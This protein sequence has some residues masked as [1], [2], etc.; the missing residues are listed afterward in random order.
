MDGMQKDFPS[1]P[2]PIKNLKWSKKAVSSIWEMGENLKLL[3][4][5]D[6]VKAAL[7]F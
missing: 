6:T 2:F 7:G 3:N 1:I 4:Y 5:Q